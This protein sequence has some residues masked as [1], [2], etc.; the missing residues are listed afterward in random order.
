MKFLHLSSFL[1]LLLFPVLAQSQENGPTEIS[2]A[3]FA[4]YRPLHKIPVPAF[5]GRE[6]AQPVQNT[7]EGLVY[8]LDSIRSCNWNAQTIAWD[9]I[10][11]GHYAYNEFGKK[12][13]YIQIFWYDDQWQQ[14]SWYVT[15][16]DA[17]GNQVEETRSQWYA[18]TNE[19]RVSEREVMIYNGSTYPEEIIRSIWYISLNTWVEEMRFTLSHDANGNVTDRTMYLPDADVTWK[20]FV[21]QEYLYDD[22]GNITSYI[23]YDWNTDSNQWEPDSKDEYTYSTDGNVASTT[24]IHFKSDIFDSTWIPVQ[25][26]R[27]TTEM[28]GNLKEII[29]SERDNGTGDLIPGEKYEELYDANGLLV[30]VLS[31]IWEGDWQWRY[32]IDYHWSQHEI[33]SNTE[34]SGFLPCLIYPNPAR[35]VLFITGLNEAAETRIYSAQGNLLKST[36]SN[37]PAA[38]LNVR[39]LPGGVYF[40]HLKAGGKTA[41]RR[42]VKQ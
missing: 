5:M 36:I 6:G 26:V 28:I 32:Q 14:H 23:D 17:A 41:V 25:E 42:F 13:D 10:L 9:S 4:L 29:V 40:V 33:I 38:E 20:P 2:P 34:E 7:G 16:Y 39:D 31:S 37:D 15:G 12:T 8:L 3:S 11:R 22:S 35:D 1:F 18:E 30:H 21:R 24:W 19:W 27:I